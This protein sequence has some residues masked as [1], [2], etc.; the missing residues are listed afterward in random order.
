MS[1]RPRARNMNPRTALFGGTF[2][3]IHNAHVEVARAALKSLHGAN[4][5]PHVDEVALLDAALGQPAE[6]RALL[7]P[8]VLDPLE[9]R[10]V[11]ER[12]AAADEPG[13]EVEQSLKRGDE[14]RT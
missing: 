14:E 7:L 12:L 10:A 6:G 11:A 9:H 13:S 8:F 5:G 4:L 1:A 3:P 2:D